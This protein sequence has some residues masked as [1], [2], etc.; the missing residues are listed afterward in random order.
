MRAICGAGQGGVVQAHKGLVQEAAPVVRVELQGRV[1]PFKRHDADTIVDVP[2]D[3]HLAL[4]TV[5]SARWCD[6]F[7]SKRFL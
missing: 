1:R 5:T 7:H 2:L 6:R 4:V 3:A